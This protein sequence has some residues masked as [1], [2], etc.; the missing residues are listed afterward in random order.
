MGSNKNP[1]TDAQENFIRENHKGKSVECLI[2]MMEA[3]FGI[4]FKTH[5]IEHFK[6]KNNLKSFGFPQEIRQYILEI[7]DN[8]T[9]DVI[10]DMVN[11]KF[12]TEYKGSQMSTFLHKRG[13]KTGFHTSI[14]QNGDEVIRAGYVYIKVDGVF[15]KKDR[16]VLEC[17][18]VKVKP[19]DKIKHLDGDLMNCELD[20][21]AIITES[22][23][24]YLNKNH[25]I[26]SDRE[27]NQCSITLAKLN[28]EVQNC[29]NTITTYAGE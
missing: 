13:M 18:H 3:E 19:N 10:A 12:H 26:S 8:K 24:L 16:Y 27:F 17:A 25:F 1:F 4:R 22:E 15:K 20:N 9:F 23:N 5:Q 11:K 28:S 29:G 2:D 6:N 7:Y 14:Y 21:L